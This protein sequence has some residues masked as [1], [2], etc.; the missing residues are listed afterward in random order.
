V[1]SA[2]QNQRLPLGQTSSSSY[3]SVSRS[4]LPS[5]MVGKLLR[6]ASDIEQATSIIVRES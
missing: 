2:E 4:S 5:G 3:C 1:E 6:A